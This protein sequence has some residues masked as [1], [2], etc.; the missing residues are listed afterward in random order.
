[1]CGCKKNVIRQNRTFRP[2]MTPR[3]V[4]GGVAAGATP[5]QVRALNA[6]T[7]TSPRQIERM[8]AQRR[9]I[10]QIRRAAIKRK[11]GS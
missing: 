4:Q 8:D 1:M 11:M 10:E 9:R 6:Q 3:A 2:A 7:A 5:E